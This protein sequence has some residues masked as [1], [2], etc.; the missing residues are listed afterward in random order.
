MCTHTNIAQYNS[1]HIHTPILCIATT[2][3]THVRKAVIYNSLGHLCITRAVQES[4][5]GQV[6]VVHTLNTLTLN[7]PVCNNNQQFLHFYCTKNKHMFILTS[8]NKVNLS[9]GNNPFVSSI[10]KS[11]LINFLKPQSLP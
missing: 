4:P 5:A 2:Y 6:T 11:L 9:S 3:N 7:I 1:T 10:K 8:Q